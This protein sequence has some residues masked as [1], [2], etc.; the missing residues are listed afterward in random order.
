MDLSIY[1]I[2]RRPVISTKAQQM[3]SKQ[4]KLVLEVHIE[5][6]KVLITQAIERL[7][8]VEVE[9][10]RTLIRKG[11]RRRIPG[12]R[13]MTMGKREKRAIVMLKP[14]YS[15]D[16]FGQSEQGAVVTTPAGT[17]ELTKKS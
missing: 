8:G 11:K 7:F 14:G 9:S 12:R 10:I 17:K 3:N 16:I 2:I 5:A 4:N 15:V 13:A 1:D 6:N